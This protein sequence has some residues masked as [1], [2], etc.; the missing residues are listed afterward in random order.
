[1]MKPEGRVVVKVVSSQAFEVVKEKR[2]Q[3]GNWCAMVRGERVV[4]YCGGGWVV[5]GE[6]E[7]GRAFILRGRVATWS[8]RRPG[9]Q[10]K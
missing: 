6:C 5:L 9:K 8:S 2:H 7:R 4:Q 1:M 3:C 10:M